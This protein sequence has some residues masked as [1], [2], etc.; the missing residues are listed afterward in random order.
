MSVSVSG[1]SVFRFIMLFLFISTP[2]FTFSQFIGD[3]Y[4]FLDPVH[5][6]SDAGS[7]GSNGSGEPD[8]KELTLLS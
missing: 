4:I 1:M 2:S 5:G 3:Y 7:P 8:G 6:G